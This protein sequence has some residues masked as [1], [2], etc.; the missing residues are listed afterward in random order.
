M[1]FQIRPAQA[2]QM[3]PTAEICGLWNAAFSPG[4]ELHERLWRQNTLD[5]PNFQPS[6]LLTARNEAGQLVGFVLTGRFRDRDRYGPA[7]PTL[8]TLLTN[9][10][11]AALAVHPAFQKQGLGRQLL[12]EA[13]AW[14]Q[15]NGAQQILL[16]E[17]FCHFFPGLP[18]AC[19]AARPLFEK[20]GFVYTT[21]DFDLE[22]SLHPDLFEPLMV[23]SDSLTFRQARPEDRVELLAFLGQVFPGRW[24][25]TLRFYLEQGYNIGDVTVLAAE[26]KI[27]GFLMTYWAGSRVLG[28]GVYWHVEKAQWG[29]I[30]PLG[31]SPSVRGN[32]AGLGLVAAGMS[33][34]YH[35]R[36]ARMC[37][38]DWTK[39]V[40]F[41][42]RLG[43]RPVQRYERFAKKA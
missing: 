2:D 31:I 27:E 32:G 34:L 41:Y 38:I 30:G 3:P 18:Q 36:Q 11:L 6:D 16:G 39:L 24:F 10:Y 37:R 19:A 26:G 9:G 12:S 28:P 8:P 29:G 33:H 7:T 1:N 5:N 13:L 20:A 4:W 35:T 17:N 42:A 21:D 15:T 14:L 25:Y 23:R 22:G 43:F 40:D